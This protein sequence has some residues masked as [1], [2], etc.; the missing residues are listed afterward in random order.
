M[1]STWPAQ[2]RLQPHRTS[3]THPSKKIS[4]RLVCTD[5]QLEDGDGNRTNQCRTIMAV[6]LRYEQISYSYRGCI[7][8]ILTHADDQRPHQRSPPTVGNSAVK[9]AH[10]S[11][12]TAPSLVCLRL[13][14]VYISF[15]IQR[16]PVR[17][18][19]DQA[20]QMTLYERNGRMISLAEWYV[21]R[22]R[23]T[24]SPGRSTGCHAC[25]H[26]VNSTAPSVCNTSSHMVVTRDN[27]DIMPFPHFPPRARNSSGGTTT[28]ECATE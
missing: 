10:V 22:Y 17:I 4:S 21:F 12:G 14:R 25:S 15:T 26:F 24:F 20:N 27:F 16:S 3:Q 6:G 13:T 5:L 2:H 7:S 1:H 8:S 11:L 28:D 19:I 9:K 23:E 18:P